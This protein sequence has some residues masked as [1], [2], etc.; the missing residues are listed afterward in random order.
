MVEVIKKTI[1][2]TIRDIPVVCL[3]GSLCYDYNLTF[4]EAK[5]SGL[6]GHEIGKSRR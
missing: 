5:I 3:I 1:T 6:A 4:L 2:L